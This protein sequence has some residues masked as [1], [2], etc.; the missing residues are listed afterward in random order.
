MWTKNSSARQGRQTLRIKYSCLPNTQ[1]VFSINWIY[2]YGD[3]VVGG[4]VISQTLTA[5]LSIKEIT[6]LLVLIEINKYEVI[7]MEIFFFERIFLWDN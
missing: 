4:C 5:L 6:E 1:N 3:K 2:D 7:K